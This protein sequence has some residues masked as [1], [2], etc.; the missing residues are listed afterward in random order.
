[1]KGTALGKPSI[2]LRPA[3]PAIVSG[4]RRLTLTSDGHP[5]DPVNVAIEG[6][7]VALVRAMHA[8]GWYPADPITLGSSLR[9]VVDSI[10]RNPPNPPTLHA[11]IQFVDEFGGTLLSGFDG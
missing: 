2:P 9:I 4:R 7:E 1:M 10:V 11:N 3:E 5:G 6:E 8:A